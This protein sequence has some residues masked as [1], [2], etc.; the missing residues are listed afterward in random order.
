MFP[1]GVHLGRA[2]ELQPAVGHMRVDGGELPQV[3]DLRA[4]EHRVVEGGRS[5]RSGSARARATLS[6]PA[7][8]VV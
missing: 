3:D 1:K 4:A 2:E 6:P 5:I 7:N 8:G